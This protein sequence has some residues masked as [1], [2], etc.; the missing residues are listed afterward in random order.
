MASKP[1]VY[2]PTPYRRPDFDF[3][4]PV[5][6]PPEPQPSEFPPS[7][8]TMK[9]KPYAK[10]LP[11]KPKAPSSEYGASGSIPDADP[12]PYVNCPLVPG[13]NKCTF[14]SYINNLDVALVMYYDPC[15][16]D[17]GIAKLQVRGASSRT[18][19]PNH[20]YLAVDC[21]T[22]TELCKMQNINTIPTYQLFS[23]GG[24]VNTYTNIENLRLVD[25]QRFVETAPL[26]DDPSPMTC[27]IKKP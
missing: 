3:S 1:N 8:F 6:E 17:S 10:V 23:R 7:K 16:P 11:P 13:L 24:L 27:Q 15:E 4:A 22:E 20:K 21:S 14:W 5:A 18:E 26:A 12:D 9:T 19:R 25:V 2:G